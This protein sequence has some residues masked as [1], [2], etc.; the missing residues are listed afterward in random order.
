MTDA[1]DAESIPSR[2]SYL[3]A[4]ST[5]ND[6]TQSWNTYNLDAKFDGSDSSWSD[7][8]GLG[9]DNNAIYITSNQYSLPLN[10]STS[11]P[12]YSRVRV[13]PKT[14]LYAGGVFSYTDFW[15]F[16]YGDGTNA[17]NVVPAHDFGSPT[18][19]YLMSTYGGASVYLWKVTNPLS[20]PTLG[21]QAIF[22]VAS[23]SEPPSAFQPGV[24]TT[25]PCVATST[26]DS[27]LEQSPVYQNGYLYGAFT[28]A[29]NWG[30]ETVSA[31][32]YFKVDASAS[33]SS[34]ATLDVTYGAD[35]LYYFYPAIYADPNGDIV[36]EFSRSGVREYINA[37]YAR[38]AAGDAATKG[39][40]EI[41]AGN[42]ASIYWSSNCGGMGGR[43]GDYAGAAL[44]PSVN[45]KIWFIGQSATSAGCAYS[46][47]SF[48]FQAPVGPKLYV[49]ANNATNIL[50]PLFV[51]HL[52]S[53]AQSYT[54]N[55]SCPNWNSVAT[56]TD[57]FDILHIT[58]PYSTTYT[59][60]VTANYAHDQVPSS[61]W[62]F[63]TP[64]PPPPPGGGGCCPYIFTSGLGGLTAENNLLPQSEA[65]AN[66]GKNVTDYYKLQEPPISKDGKYLLKLGE[67]EHERSSF[68]QVQLIAVDHLKGTSIAVMRDG[69]I[70][71]YAVPYRISPTGSTLPFSLSENHATAVRLREGQS[72][73]IQ[74]ELD[75][76]QANAL[77]KIAGDKFDLSSAHAGLVLGGQ[78]DH[79]G[80][81]SPQK[82]TCD[83]GY[84]G[85]NEAD[86]EQMQ[87][88]FRERSAVYYTP[89]KSI[90]T[91][92]SMTFADYTLLDYAALAIELP[93]GYTSNALPLLSAHHS[94]IG[95]V[96]LNLSQ[97]DGDAVSL[98]PGE[99]ITMEFGSP[100]L[101]DGMVR[102]FIVVTT[103]RYTSETN[104]DI[105]P[106]EFPT[107]FSLSQNYP[108]PFNPA[109][110]IRYTLPQPGRVTLKIYN[111][112]GQEIKTL[113]DANQ[114][115]GPKSVTFDAST[116]PSGIYLYK[117]Q[118]GNYLAVKKLALIK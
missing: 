115:P 38:R 33:G 99:D 12:L 14:Q 84:I 111:L 74:F 107:Q 96:A 75:P 36:L 52:V 68:D 69:S 62:T 102:D 49:P 5:S 2:S 34:S 7:Y 11:I 35:H 112:L 45:S 109:T 80:K 53:G 83:Q 32:R 46:V 18:G 57:T 55:V 63:S 94:R 97:D 22:A 88:A 91:D 42:A 59:W 16:T 64:P 20:N 54:L 82:T 93:M 43:W 41:L 118:A 4:V 8:P 110:V 30:H 28:A 25:N 19:G 31:I 92:M 105:K 95:E 71:Q 26:L 3:L 106:T 70:V 27:R 50:E 56:V 86:G 72:A 61:T 103:G 85:A 90:E 113:V 23:Y 6:P 101:A 89:L 44:D 116:L 104:S 9:F 58:F 66:L 79:V 17:T 47:A 67:F 24:D 87:F 100:S 13:I 81:R 65:S 117:L 29:A 1:F 114:S 21:I 37:R 15:N 40:N 10:Y 77:K 73:H 60:N 76:D 48:D 39:S 98:D 108:N 51:W 78:T